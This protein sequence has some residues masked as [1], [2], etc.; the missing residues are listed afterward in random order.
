M[1]TNFNY[2]TNEDI[3]HSIVGTDEIDVME[4]TGVNNSL[5]LLARMDEEELV[6][7]KGMTKKRARRLMLAFELGKRLFEEK[8]HYNN[9][10]SSIAIYQYLRPRMEFKNT[11]C[12]Y[13]VIMNQNFKE[14]ATIKLSEGGITETAVD[15]REIIKQTTL[16][17]GTIIALAHNHPCGCIT[18]SKNDDKLTCQIAKACEI[19]RI[20]FMDH[21]I[22]GDGAFYSYHDKGKL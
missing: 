13:L 1:E 14:L 3:I 21:I 10:G 11:E 8:H 18:P 7:I 20:F 9:L 4:S 12:M 2:M 16:R 6:K 15:I 19:M 17:N 22:I 5:A